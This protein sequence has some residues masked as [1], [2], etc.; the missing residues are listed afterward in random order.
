MKIAFAEQYGCPVLVL[1]GTES[2]DEVYERAYNDEAT[3]NDGE[4]VCLVLEFPG[5]FPELY[6]EAAM[7]RS[8]GRP[9]ISSV[10]RPNE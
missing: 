7:R 6:T 1:D 9:I 8:L 2:P 3:Y 10:E 4:D 5:R